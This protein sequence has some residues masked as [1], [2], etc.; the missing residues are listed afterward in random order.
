MELER[1]CDKTLSRSWEVHDS[2]QSAAKRSAKAVSISGSPV[3]A[4]ILACV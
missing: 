4:R 1:E 3:F 2:I